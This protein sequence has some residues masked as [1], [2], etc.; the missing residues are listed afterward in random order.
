MST[1]LQTTGK[2]KADKT[3]LLNGVIVI[4]ILLLLWWLFPTFFTQFSLDSTLWASEKLS[5]YLTRSSGTVA[6]IVLSASTL[7]GL[8][9]SSKLIKELVPAPVALAM[10]NAL[11]WIAL[12]LAFFHAFVLLFD[13]YYT[14][15]VSNLLIPFT[16][17]YQPLWVGVGTLGFYLMLLLSATFYMRR[18]IGAK[19]WRQL[20]YLT[21][22][23]Y[24]M[25]TLHG[26]L[27]G[28]DSAV[29]AW[30]YGTSALTVI[31][32]TLY[33]IVAAIREAGSVPQRKLQSIAN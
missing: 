29:F 27:A 19:R 26:W 16:G 17:P 5:W 20:H 1:L 24:A 7:W 2:G 23:G 12:G 10:H 4:E 8:L 14:Y 18:W 13:N 15:T 11:S 9:L 28:T 33:R 21:F 25:I 30:L 32:L 6:Y 22:A 31:F 3:R